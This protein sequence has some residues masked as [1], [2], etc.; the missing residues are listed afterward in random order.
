MTLLAH[1]HAVGSTATPLIED[2]IGRH[3]E[4]MARRFPD[5]DALV[6]RHQGKRLSYRE[7]HVQSSQLASALLRCGLSVGDRAGIWAHNCCE[8]LLMQLAT[9]KVGIILVNINPAYRVTELEY[10][11]NKVGCKLLMT[12][13]AY[14]TSDYLAIVRE[15]APELASAVPGQLRGARVPQRH[16]IVHLGEG[17]EPGMLSFAQLM[18]SHVCSANG[19]TG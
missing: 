3:F 6:S 19:D 13:T 5:R 9:A 8:W 7:L 11:M 1:S 16:T 18:E 2:T 15:L 10:A 14:K 17:A 4:A 12:M